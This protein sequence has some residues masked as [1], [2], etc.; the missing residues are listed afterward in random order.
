[1][2]GLFSGTFAGL[3]IIGSI[4]KIGETLGAPEGYFKYGVLVMA[5]GNA[6]GRAAW[7][8]LVEWIGARRAVAAD[9]A[10]QAACVTAMIFAGHYGPAF[11]V[12]AFLIGFNYGGNFVLYVTEVAHTYGPDKVAS[13]YGLIYVVYVVSGLTG[14]S[15]AGASSDHWRTYVPSM[16]LA[17]AVALAGAAG[18]VA[19][20]KRPAAEG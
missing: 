18:F 20:Y 19:L 14:P 2:V 11:V 4:E 9:L 15:A 6:L 12:L 10:L 13:V 16:G 3:S 5:I 1:V 7:G 17:A 8:A